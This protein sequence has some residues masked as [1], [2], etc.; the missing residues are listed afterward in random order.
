MHGV[1]SQRKEA[2]LDIGLETALNSNV[3][4][5]ILQLYSASVLRDMTLSSPYL[6][7]QT[8]ALM[9]RCKPASRGAASGDDGSCGSLSLFCYTKWDVSSYVGCAEYRAVIMRSHHI[10]STC[11]YFPKHFASSLL[12]K[13]LTYPNALLLVLVYTCLFHAIRAPNPPI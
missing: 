10:A 7:G 5:P 3:I 12:T 9:T 1:R 4:S 11:C 13:P 8:E 6:Q 2:P